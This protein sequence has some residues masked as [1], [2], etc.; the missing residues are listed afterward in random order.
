MVDSSSNS[1]FSSPIEAII[2]DVDGTLYDQRRL[3]WRMF[4]ILLTYYILRPWR[5]GE[6]LVLRKF[7]L[8]R[9]SNYRLKPENLE[10][11]QY[12]WCA[13]A[14]GVT[15]DEVKRIVHKWIYQ[16]PLHYLAPCL[17]PGVAEFISE[18]QDAGI[19]VACFSD[20]PAQDKL[21]AMGLP[22]LPCF[23]ATDMAINCLKPEPDG[24]MIIGK[25]L[26]VPLSRCLLIGD[27]DDRDG[28]CARRAG[29]KYLLLSSDKLADNCFYD[30]S[31]LAT[32]WRRNIDAE[33]N[34]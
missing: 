19:K 8:L 25:T 24:L 11:A 26:N 2:F 32:W 12:Q 1:I 13:D 29:V 27:R 3:R 17:Y 23:A 15:V 14:T 34:S 21:S 20:Y 16:Q 10:L 7:R 28:E 5:I 4:W 31:E 30:Y 22:A 18:L 9:E 33:D 6:L